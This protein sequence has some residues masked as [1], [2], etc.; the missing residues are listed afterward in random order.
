MTP[1]LQM[2]K[3]KGGKSSDLSKVVYLASELRLL[4]I[5]HMNS[6]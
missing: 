3:L 4:T 5:A 6:Y 2:V 1:I